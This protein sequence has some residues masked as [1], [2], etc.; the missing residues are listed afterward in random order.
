MEKISIKDFKKLY[1]PPKDSH[2][3]QNGRLMIIAGSEMYHGASI[4]P[5]K[6]A[7]RIV[8][9]VYFSSVH[10]N[11]EIVQKMKSELPDFIVLPRKKIWEFI[12]KMD[13]VM[14]G[15][16]L[17]ENRKTKK[18]TEK[19]L[20]KYPDKKFLL[21]ADSLK[22]IN[23][24]F[25][26]KN[27]IIT[28]HKKEFEKI[29]GVSASKKNVPIMSKKYGCI[30]VL[31]GSEDMVCSPEYCRINNTGNQGMSKGG[32]GDV[33]SGLISALACKNDL[34]LSACAG[35]FING[36]SGDRLK[37]KVSYYYNVSNLAEEIPKTMKWLEDH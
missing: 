24:K 10:E 30:I 27:C 2:K 3:G 34:F 19:L 9:L 33:L 11:N 36:L 8:D 5:L 13:C 23:P 16:G 35:V 15:P 25:L 14:I 6:V 32:T 18:L 28:P 1:V 20:K 4:L 7:S 22:I 29:F 37:K 21:D 31:K 12:D 17:G 26:T